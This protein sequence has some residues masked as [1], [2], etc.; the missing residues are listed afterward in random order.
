MK[1]G[2][3]SIPDDM[4]RFFWFHS[5]RETKLNLARQA[6]TQTLPDVELMTLKMPG[7]G[8]TGTATTIEYFRKWVS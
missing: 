8:Y 6:S 4:R 3:R 7:T 5:Q 2:L 1:Q